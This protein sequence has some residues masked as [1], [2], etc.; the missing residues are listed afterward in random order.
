AVLNACA[1]DIDAAIATTCDHY[2]IDPVRT[3]FTVD[4]DTMRTRGVLIHTPSLLVNA[5]HCSAAENAGV[6][7]ATDCSPHKKFNP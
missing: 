5:V 3:A 2:N 4:P 1:A 7:C 6:P